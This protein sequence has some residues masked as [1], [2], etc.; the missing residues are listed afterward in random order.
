LQLNKIYDNV[1]APDA[2]LQL[3]PPPLIGFHGRA[4][5][6]GTPPD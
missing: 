4:S 1:Y 3:S 6:C 2:G 5:A